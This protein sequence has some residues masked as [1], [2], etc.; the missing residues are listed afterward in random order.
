VHAGQE[1]EAGDPIGIAGGEK[2]TSGAHLRFFV[3][4][5]DPQPKATSNGEP[6]RKLRWAYVTP[7]F[8]TKENANNVLTP[9]NNYTSEKPVEIITQEMTKGELKK[10]MKKHPSR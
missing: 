5:R 4:Y 7:V 9:G 3:Y 6:G 1:V 2:Y 10:W 8:Y